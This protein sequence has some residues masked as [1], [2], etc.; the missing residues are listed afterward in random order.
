VAVKVGELVGGRFELEEL[1]GEGGMSS[2]YR[3]YD[4]E[5]ERR[6]AVKILHEHYSSDPE[7]VERF[8]REARAIARLSHPNVVTVID[9][10]EW[11]GRQYIVFEHVAGENL[12]AIVAR[13][14]PLPLHEALELSIQVGR[15]LAFAHELGIVHRDVKPHNVLVD[16]GGTAKVTDFG[17]A[18]ALDVDDALTQTGTVLGTGLYISPEQARGERGDERS[19]QYS[20]GVVMYELLTGDVPYRGD[21]LM[22]VAMRHVRDPVPHVREKRPD[23]PARVDAVVA[24]TMAKQPG[25]RYPSLD[26]VV[27]ALE[28]CRLPG[29]EDTWPVEDDAAQTRV[30]APAP[31]PASAPGQQAPRRRR[32]LRAPIALAALVALGVIAALVLLGNGV[33]GLGGDTA[34]AAVRATAVADFDPQGGDGEHPET[35][36]RATDGDV[37]TFW[38]TEIYRSFDKDG[39]GIVIE[40]PRRV[41]LS[42]LVVESDTPG[43]TAMV[44]AGPELV[45]R[46]S[47]VS[48]ETQIERRTEIDVD[49]HGEAFRYYVLWITSLEGSA[50]VNEVRAF[51]AA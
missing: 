32:R 16:A 12:K 14:G 28:R 31:A 44:L 34:E 23:V 9:R 18:R 11:R 2:V 5:L 49:T 4:S 21:T 30:V 24:R 19:D 51:R 50:H 47:G 15:A 27:E 13:E 26:D 8:R 10:G 42:R 38:S 35:V 40:V 33:F 45:G 39:V 20:F 22:A 29:P 43:F 1:V 36:G 3:A 7:Y 46:F 6:V 48:D 25:D 41:R 17:I 37:A